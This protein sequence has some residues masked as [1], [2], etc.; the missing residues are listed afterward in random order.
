MKR[1]R[2][3]VLYLDAADNSVKHYIPGPVGERSK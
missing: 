2:T 3:G 1:I